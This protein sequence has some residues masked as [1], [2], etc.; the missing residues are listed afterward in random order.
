MAIEPS[1]PDAGT[2]QIGEELLHTAE[3]GRSGVGRV[4]ASQAVAEKLL[5]G[6]TLLEQHC[7]RY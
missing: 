2:S 7:P 5:Q 1:F 4:D 6:W 3:A